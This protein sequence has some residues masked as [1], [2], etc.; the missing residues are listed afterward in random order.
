MKN[1]IVCI[2]FAIFCISCK[3]SQNI[4]STSDNQFQIKKIK[5]EKFAYIIDAVKNDSIFKII[6]DKKDPNLL[7]CKKIKKGKYYDLKLNQI[8][9]IKEANGSYYSMVKE[10]EHKGIVIKIDRKF[11]STVYS[12]VNL[13]GICIVE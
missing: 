12:V 4:I 10:F 9:P 2:L 1:F 5:E 3:Q 8:F 11:H 13:N 7:D 6:S